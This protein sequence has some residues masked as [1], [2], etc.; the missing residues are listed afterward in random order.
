MYCVYNCNDA[1]IK[2]TKGSVDMRLSRQYSNTSMVPL[3]CPLSALCGRLGSLGLHM[4]DC[5]II[6]MCLV[7][8]KPSITSGEDVTAGRILQRGHTRD[9]SKV[10]VLIKNTQG[11]K[12][13]I[14]YTSPTHHLHIYTLRTHHLHVT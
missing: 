12:I 2:H 14:T 4:Y 10:I 5:Q 8:Y 1:A 9:M 13:Y 3:T 11:V 7:V 6:M